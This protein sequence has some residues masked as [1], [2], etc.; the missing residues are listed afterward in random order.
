MR[1][2]G[3]PR[4]SLALVSF[5]LV[6][7]IVTATIV[8][9]A[10]MHLV[11]LPRLRDMAGG[12]QVFDLRFLGYDRTDAVALLRALGSEGRAEYLRVQLRLDDAFAPLYGLA[13]SLA[14]AEILGRAGLGRV[15]SFLL[16]F[17]VV[18]PTAGFD[19]AENAAI[20]ELLRRP[21]D[22]LDQAVVAVASF[23]TTTKWAF[24]GLGAAVALTGILLANRR[25]DR[26]YDE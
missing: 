10:A 12:L 7:A 21:P 19:I 5:A 3:R 26:D 23:R 25:I 9:F 2:G 13:L 8:L 11:T 17:A 4:S 15:A 24:A 22:T 6:V 1:D 16:A 18:L 20:A 14:L